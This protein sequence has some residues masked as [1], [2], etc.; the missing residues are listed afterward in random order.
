MYYETK[1]KNGGKKANFLDCQ[2]ILRNDV[3]IIR[4]VLLTS[5]KIK[6]RIIHGL[7][8]QTF[9]IINTLVSNL[10]LK[11]TC[12]EFLEDR[13]GL[14]LSIDT[15]NVPLALDFRGHNDILMT[16]ASQ[17]WSLQIFPEK[18]ADFQ[19]FAKNPR[20]MRFWWGVF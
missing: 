20:N 18:Y 10:P 12:I 2:T 7:Y 16:S 15:K 9:Q 13:Y 6:S 1:H 4:H 17:K 19:F 8:F 3:C 11:Y 14:L 5:L